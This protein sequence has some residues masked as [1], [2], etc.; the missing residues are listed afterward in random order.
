ML[1]VNKKAKKLSR[2]QIVIG[3]IIGMLVGMLVG[4]N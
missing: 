1:I 3:T 4:I 2:L